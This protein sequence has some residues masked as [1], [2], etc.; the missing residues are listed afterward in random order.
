M[1]IE[2]GSKYQ[3]SQS[4][5]GFF[6]AAETMTVKSYNGVTVQ[7]ILG[8]SKGHGSMPVEHLQYLLKKSNLTVIPNKRSLLN[9]EINEEQIG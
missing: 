5:K 7:F 8:D 6:N 2:E 3:I 1:I 9:T 4:V